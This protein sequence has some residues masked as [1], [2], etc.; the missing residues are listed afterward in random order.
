MIHQTLDIG[1][2][3]GEGFQCLEKLSNGGLETEK[4]D[5]ST[6]WL[7]CCGCQTSTTKLME[8]HIWLGTCTCC[9][10]H[11][12][13]IFLVMNEL[14]LFVSIAAKTN[15][16]FDQ[17]PLVIHPFHL[18]LVYPEIRDNSVT[19]CGYGGSR[20]LINCWIVLYVQVLLDNLLA[21]EAPHFLFPP[22]K[23]HNIQLDQ[24]YET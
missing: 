15:R 1:P 4:G 10:C 3:R 17:V 23:H 7:H 16:P 11:A 5:T 22:G 24:L 21:R 14:C 2:K 18:C 13:V 8:E 20:L 6:V 9:Q 19:V 12:S